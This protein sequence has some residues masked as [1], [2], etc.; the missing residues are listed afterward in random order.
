LEICSGTFSLNIPLD[1]NIK[2]THIKERKNLSN[3]LWTKFAMKHQK[4]KKKKV[5]RTHELWRRVCRNKSS[6]GGV[7]RRHTWSLGHRE[8]QRREWK[9]WVWRDMERD[10]PFLSEGKKKLIM[11]PSSVTN[12]F[13]TLNLNLFLSMFFTLI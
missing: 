10:D 8:W 5:W 7:R 3:I 2:Q 6:F 12:T 4:V 13:T 11:V 1:L 9:L